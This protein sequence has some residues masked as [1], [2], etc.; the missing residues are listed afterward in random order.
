MALRKARHNLHG[1]SGEV[2]DPPTLLAFG[3]PRREFQPRAAWVEVPGFDSLRLLGTR[4]RLPA[5]FEQVA[6]VGTLDRRQQ[7]AELRLHHNLLAARGHGLL[8]VSDRAFLYVPHLLRPKEGA[9]HGG[10]GFAAVGAAPVGVRV[11]SREDVMGLQL[12]DRHVGG[13]SELIDETL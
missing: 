6:E 8:D 4:T 7:L 12:L 9:L 13:V 3:F 1:P 11:H 2:N 5:E 10:D